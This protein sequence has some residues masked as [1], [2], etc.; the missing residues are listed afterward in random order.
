MKAMRDGYGEMLVE[1][2][3]KNGNVVVL[4]GDLTESTRTDL[5]REEFPERFFEMGISE[6]NMMGV[7][8]GMAASGKIPLVNSFACFNPGRN[9][10]QMKISVCLS[11]TNVKVVG[12]H[13]GFGNGGDG[14]NQQSFEDIALVRVL[15]NMTVVVPADYEQIKKAVMEITE[16]TGPV[17]MRMTKPNRPVITTKATPFKIGKA[18]VMRAGKDVSVFACGAM[19][20]EALLAASELA[21]EIDVEVVNVHTIKPLD[22]ETLVASAKKTRKVVTAE[23]H[24]IAGGLGGAVAELLSVEMPVPMMMVGMS[25]KFGESGD[26]AELLVKHGMNKETIISKIRGLYGK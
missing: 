6:Q 3:K 19:V 9:W 1:M 8:A 22:R 10:E 26:P 20:Y 25:D 7:A 23:E 12:G 17:Y 24:Q 2:G 15:P 13:A 11:K 14:G 5:F 18:Q 16:F 4:V 21:N